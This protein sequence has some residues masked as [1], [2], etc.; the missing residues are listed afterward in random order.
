M[1]PQRPSAYEQLP[2]EAAARIDPACDRFEEVWKAVRTGGR[3]PVVDSFLDGS[4]ERERTV[5]AAELAALDRQ[6]RQRYGLAQPTDRLRE[7]GK[8]AERLSDTVV[9]LERPFVPGPMPGSWPSVPGLVLEKVLGSGG[10]GVVFKARQPTLDREVAVKFLR[11]GHSAESGH[12]ERFKQEARAVARLQHPNLVQLYEFGEASRADGLGS[13]PYLVL[14]YVSGGS[15][16]QRLREG[17]LPPQE[18][19]QLVETV[20]EA[21][22]Y[23]HQQG[24]IH[25]DLKPANVL[26]TS[27]PT[28]TPKV[29]DFGLAKFLVGSSLTQTGDVLGTPSYMAPEQTAGK[30]GV[31]TP[32]VDVYGL[33]AIL[34]EA[35][36]GRPPFAGQT[37]AATVRQVQEDEP[38]SPRRIEQVVPHDLETICMKCLRKEP[39][40]R[41]KSAQELADD[42]H[43]FR[44]GEPIQARPV[45]TA[46][47]VLGWCRRRPLVA[48]LVAALALVILAGLGVAG[49]QWELNREKE[50][51]FKREQVKN[52]MLKEQADK[53][54][55]ALREKIDGLSK[56]A[57]A[58]KKDP[59]LR[60][61]ALVVLEEALGFY[62][63]LVAQYGDDP[64]LR[65]QGARL[66]G[67]VAGIYHTAGRWRESERTF[68]RH[69]ELLAALVQDERDNP[70][71][72]RNLGVSLRTRGNVL[73]DLG[74]TE[75][76]RAVYERAVKV[77]EQA[78]NAASPR[79][80]V[81]LANTLI[82]LATVLPP[83]TGCD[84]FDKLYGRVI[85]L[86][87]DAVAADDTRPYYQSELALALDD[88]GEYLLATG[89]VKEA[90][91]L[92]EEALEIRQ[93]LHASGKMPMPLFYRRYVARSYVNQGHVLAALG[94]YPEAE[95]SYTE[96]EK[97]LGPLL[98]ERAYPFYHQELAQAYFGRAELFKRL[99]RKGDVEKAL[100][101]A[102][103]QYRIIKDNFP[104]DKP[105]RATLVASYLKLVA[106]LWEVGRGEDAAKPYALAFQVD[107]DDPAVNDTLA[108]FLANS[109]D[110]RLRKPEEAVRLA[111]RATDASTTN[112]RYWTTLGAA[113]YRQGN[114][115][116]AIAAL[117]E[118]LRLREGGDAIEWLFL[119]MAHQRA[120]NPA[121]AQKWLERA[122]R[123]MDGCMP[124]TEELRR[125][126]AEAQAAMGK[127]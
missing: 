32:A 68:E 36:S 3:P 47:R 69:A 93:K 112:G 19:A 59:Q 23:A 38:V 31:I 57:A 35:L 87:R 110:Q 115:E 90:R 21:I 58:L 61:A 94:K 18:A 62:G 44:R 74:E 98:K 95:V 27:G 123:R 120:G 48:G 60:D 22:H 100:R 30:S 117:D 17:R 84:V 67:E 104:E 71:R 49:W 102:V 37:Q 83:Q 109:A 75:R 33:G 12:R 43:R 29:T 108:W 122:T 63:T 70:E 106:W 13:Q 42:L 85:Q 78:P 20:A 25:R 72:H 73:R 96:A 55:D 46:E 97:L 99:D 89:R 26:L 52:Q 111:K 16:S 76:A 9:R 103:E 54:F 2:P 105:A 81:D 56:L 107:P 91:P 119:A 14:E 121:Q 66:Y 41:Y 113:H 77:L 7:A 1:D 127:A 82:N 5:L 45:G 65:Q 24:V 79:I 51:E 39:G 10:M 101:A 53:N 126:R 40:Q 88:H 11:D 4:E 80:Q 118:A 50:A 64:R 92:I 116:A 15:L 6:C 8:D 86:D 114:D 124:L 125:L 34:Y 28:A